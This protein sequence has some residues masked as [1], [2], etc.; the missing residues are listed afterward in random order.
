[1]EK[2]TIDPGCVFCPQP[3]YVI[4][5]SNTDGTPDFSVI[6]W[7]GFCWDGCP[8]LMLGIGGQ[9]R[10]KDNIF[11]TGEFTANLVSRDWLKLADYFG[12]S[13]GTDGVKNALPFACEAGK[14]VQAPVLEDSRWVFECSVR[15]TVRLEESDIFI[16]KIETIRIDGKLKE[17]DKEMIDLQALDPVL[18]AP[19][20]YYA[21]GEKLGECGFWN[22]V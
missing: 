18:Y 12:N 11:R 2:I 6:T 13:K 14:K 1:M 7:I 20:N 3:V 19:Y 17:M 10:T 5:T 4:G 15:K 9:K 21:V 22:K 16:A 8:H